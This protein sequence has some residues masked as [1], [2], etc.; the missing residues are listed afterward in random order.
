MAGDHVERY[1]VYK[2][3]NS[4]LYDFLSVFIEGDI[5]IANK[6]ADP[7]KFVGGGHPESLIVFAIV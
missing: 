1:T 6:S 3:I 2:I 4:G 7:A 5:N